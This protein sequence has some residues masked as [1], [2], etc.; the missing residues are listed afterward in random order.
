ML[1]KS[2]GKAIFL[3]SCLTNAMWLIFEEENMFFNVSRTHNY[4]ELIIVLKCIAT[5]IEYFV[6]QT[7][8]LK[9][10]LF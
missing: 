6:F 2:K 8:Y 7:F 1:N 3:L 10:I 9:E 5:N 4:I